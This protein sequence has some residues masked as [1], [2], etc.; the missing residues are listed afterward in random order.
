MHR[1]AQ[2]DNTQDVRDF[3]NL[4]MAG[5]SSKLWLHGPDS[6]LIPG[7]TYVQRALANVCEVH[8]AHMLH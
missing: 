1:A 5:S 4:Y 7:A 2:K 8:A 3:L 6:D